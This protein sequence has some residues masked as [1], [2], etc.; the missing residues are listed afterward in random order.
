MLRIFNPYVYIKHAH[1]KLQV[2]FLKL[3][4]NKNNIKFML[5]T[6]ALDSAQVVLELRR[7]ILN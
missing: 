6:F 3:W 2:Q 1:R 7:D 4:L 5:H